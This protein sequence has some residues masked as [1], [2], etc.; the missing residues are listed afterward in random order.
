V[1]WML[2]LPPEL[3]FDRSLSR[4]H[5]RGALRGRVPEEVR[6]RPHKSYFD[7][8][9]IDSLLGGD[10]PLVRE[11]LLAPDAL[12]R[13]YTDPEQV[14]ELIERPSPQADASWG[15][16]VMQLL[17]GECWLR[18]QADQG[19]AANM[20]EHPALLEPQLRW[21]ASGAAS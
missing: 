13:R 5:Q 8:I 19:F 14:R 7:S 6:L 1:L 21:R 15:A 16:Q 4:P 12:T 9:R 2:R 17:T 10:L 20:L 3:S 11:L 18:Q